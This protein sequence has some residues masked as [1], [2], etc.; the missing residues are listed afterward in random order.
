MIS[1]YDCII[2]YHLSVVLKQIE[3]HIA[4]KPKRNPPIPANSS[5]NVNDGS[6]DEVVAAVIVLFDFAVVEDC[7]SLILALRFLRVALRCI[8]DLRTPGKYTPLVCFKNFTRSGW[9]SSSAVATIGGTC[10]SNMLPPSSLSVILR[11]PM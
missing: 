1:A 11:G 8:L 4:S 3:T 7:S 6:N 9:S 5:E 2:S 10:I